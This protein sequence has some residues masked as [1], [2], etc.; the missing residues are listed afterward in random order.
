VHGDT[1]IRVL[2]HNEQ[3]EYPAAVAQAAE[4]LKVGLLALSFLSLSF[5]SV[6]D[7]VRPAACCPLVPGLWG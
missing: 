2:S 4:E 1:L 6:V 5:L 7:T 3:G